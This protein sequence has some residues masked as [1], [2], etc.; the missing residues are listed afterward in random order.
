MATKTKRRQLPSLARSRTKAPRTSQTAAAASAAQG[1][2]E[3]AND[4]AKGGAVKRGTH[5]QAIDLILADAVA[6]DEGSRVVMLAATRKGKTGFDR[7]LVAAILDKGVAERALIH[8]QKYPQR[9]QYEG[10]QVLDVAQLREAYARV[11]EVVDRVGDAEDL[12]TLGREG[13]ENGIKT[14][15]VLDEGDYALK[16]NDQGEPIERVWLG[17]NLA[18]LQLQ[19]GGLGAST[20]INWQLLRKAPSSCVDSAQVFV[21]GCLGGRSLA[22]ALD[23]RVIPTEAVGTVKT[24]S[25]GEFCLFFTDREWDRTVYY[26]PEG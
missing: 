1:E 5:E 11:P 22:G 6:T 12:A 10:A 14:L 2:S 16:R 24:L 20:L 23:N 8:D 19:G 13:V 3:S 7:K 15:V 9:A 17:P 18:W 26:S 21:V 4:N 25:P